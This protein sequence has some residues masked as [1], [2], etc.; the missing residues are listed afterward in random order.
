[1]TKI[2]VVMNAQ[3]EK[4]MDHMKAAQPDHGI[5][6]TIFDTKTGQPVN[7]ESLGDLFM[8]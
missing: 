8:P 5:W 2:H 3:V 7:S 4:V 6:P 1:M